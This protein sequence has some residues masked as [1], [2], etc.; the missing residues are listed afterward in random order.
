MSG[1]IPNFDN[2]GNIPPEG[3][4]NPTLTEFKK[5][6]VD[7]SSNPDY[8]LKLFNGYKKYCSRLLSLGITQKQWVDGSYTA[9]FPEP[10]DVDILNHVDGNLVDQKE[11]ENDIAFCNE[12]VGL[13]DDKITKPTYFCH[14]FYLSVYPVGDTPEYKLY[15]ENYLYWLKTFGE[16][17]TERR[18]PKGIIEFSI[19]DGRFRL[20]NV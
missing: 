1:V 17:K 8:R 15:V 6:F 9:I 14:A 5:R 4:I 12:F 2:N 3:I 7:D 10:N 19:S 11:R 16:D 18:N 20:E 13:C